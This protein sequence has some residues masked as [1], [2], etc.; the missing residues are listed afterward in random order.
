[1][2][3]INKL[4]QTKTTALLYLS[5]VA[6][7]LLIIFFPWENKTQAKHQGRLMSVL[8]VFKQCSDCYYLSFADTGAPPRIRVLPAKVSRQYN[9]AGLI[10]LWSATTFP[11]YVC[12]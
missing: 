12:L 10:D 5:Y 1:M 4:G 6:G 11:H 2:L 3:W 7:G 8:L 9:M